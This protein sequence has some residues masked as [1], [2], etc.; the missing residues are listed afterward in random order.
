[1]GAERR[2]VRLAAAVL[3]IAVTSSCSAESL[4]PDALQAATIQIDG[5]ERSYHL[6]MP[7]GAS[8]PVP[9]VMVFHGGLGDGLKVA[10]QTRFHVLG[11]AR[12]F[13]VVY[14]DS[15]GYWGDGRAQTS[16]YAAGDLAFVRAIAARLVGEGKVDAR[17]I[18]ATGASNGGMFT[19]R[20]ACEA[21]DLFA[22]FA[23]VIA[24]FPVDYAARCRPARPVPLMMVNGTDDRFI[25]WQGGEIPSGRERGAGGSVIPVPDTIEFWRT[26]NGC[27]AAPVTE[28]LPD[29]D[30]NDGTTVQVERFPDCRPSGELVAVRVVGGGHTWPDSALEP[31]LIVS[32]LVGNVS[33]DV[34]GA[35]LVW[36]F[37]APLV[38]PT[39]TGAP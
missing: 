32:L 9:L 37:F 38:R 19:L 36:N 14:P 20:L 17:R 24:S 15:L 33:R 7:P 18:Y 30:P 26:H 27:G 3:L 39:Q 12:G 31:P 4:P 1:M 34:D 21:D 23:A 8:R 29:R 10:R 2:V 28:M 35:E 16:R 5:V 11:A 6:F 25:Q 13:A 22:G